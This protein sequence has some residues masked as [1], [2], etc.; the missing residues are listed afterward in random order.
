MKKFFWLI[1]F[2]I[3]IS[4]ELPGEENAYMFTLKDLDNKPV[5]LASFRGKV[6]FLD[7]WASWCPPCRMSIPEVE[8]LYQEMKDRGV[9]V[10]GINVENSPETARDF[11]RSHQLK[12]PVLIGDDQSTRAY[13]V[14]GIPAFFIISPDGKI[15]HRYIGF[16]PAL[17]AQWRSDIKKLLPQVIQ[18][19][20]TGGQKTLKKKR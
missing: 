14:R 4:G 19:K 1:T 3:L 6:V 12:Y 15:A 20:K 2:V 10:L 18:K 9:V 7:F 17:A 5:S 16:Q 13:Q 11:V 8:K